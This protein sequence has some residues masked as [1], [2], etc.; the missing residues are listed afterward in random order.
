MKMYV[1]N[2]TTQRHEFFYYVPGQT[3]RRQLTIQPFGQVVL[4]D[5]L[6]QEAVDKIVKQNEK[7][8]FVHADEVSKSRQRGSFAPLC[9]RID[10]PV[11]ASRIDTLLR[12]NVAILDAQG[13]QLR[14]E[15]A[16]AS[17]QEL[18][19]AVSNQAPGLEK[20]DIGKVEVTVQ[21]EVNANDD[22]STKDTVS[23][24]YKIDSGA[25]DARGRGRKR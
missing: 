1:A 19:R 7:Y 6:N 24:G 17:N 21:Q 25:G 15:A 18:V 20:I 2:P 12:G 13:K 5:N 10:G 22:V 8:G 23:E 16:I 14:A 4:A 11:P 9:Y 3:K